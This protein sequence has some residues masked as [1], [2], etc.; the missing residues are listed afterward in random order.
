M[1]EFCHLLTEQCIWSSKCSSGTTYGNKL[2]L[3]WLF[4]R[5]GT[6]FMGMHTALSKNTQKPEFVKSY[7]TFHVSLLIFSITTTINKGLMRHHIAL[8]GNCSLLLDPA[9]KSQQ[10]LPSPESLNMT[11]P[12]EMF[13]K[14]FLMGMPALPR[15]GGIRSSTTTVSCHLLSFN[16]FTSWAPN[17]SLHLAT[18]SCKSKSSRALIHT[19][20]FGT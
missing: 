11:D 14:H 5:A 2:I 9:A 10:V 4:C 19:F 1:L 7:L 18:S 13:P 6:K 20:L 15:I 16:P 12:R 3:L 17:N 8:T